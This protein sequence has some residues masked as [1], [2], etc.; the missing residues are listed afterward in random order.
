MSFIRIVFLSG[1]FLL[2]LPLLHH[3]YYIEQMSTTVVA[4]VRSNGNVTYPEIP[5]MTYA[6]ILLCG[7]ALVAYALYFAA[8]S[9]R[10]GNLTTAAIEQGA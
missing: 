4:V 7:V 1:V 2:A 3:A 6:A 8:R 5:Y 9:F 10:S